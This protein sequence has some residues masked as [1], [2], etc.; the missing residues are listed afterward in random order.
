MK[1]RLMGLMR[2][3]FIQFFRDKAL[4]LL[5]L[6]TFVEIAI[7]G[8]ALTLEVRNLPTAVYDGDR[9]AESQA[10]VE[11]FVQRESF[12][13]VERLEDP[14]AV[15]RLMDRGEV[16]FALIIPAG[17]SQDLRAGRSAKV[18]IVVDGSNSSIAG[19]A[20]ADA[21]DLLREYNAQVVLAQTTRG[22]PGKQQL[23]TRVKNQIQVLYMPQLK[24]VHFIML[25]ML[26]ISV[27][28]LGVLVPAAAIVREKEAGT[29]EQLMITPITG[30]ELITAKIVPM[31]LL[32]LVGLTIGV[33]MSMWIF[34]VPLRGSLLLFYAISV[35][36]FLSS[37]G[38]GVLMGTIARN[39]QQTLL[40]AF[41]ILFPLAF[42]SGTIVP[43]Q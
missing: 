36:M 38:I 6:Y 17:F 22:G 15:D 2:K 11:A 16:Q 34:G 3:E 10:L 39:M 41:F 14:A 4:V 31:V 25:T 13:L 8:W 26:A 9:S 40:L 19:Q 20:L 5:I 32:K 29:F 24:Y 37:S 1:R 18:Q 30:A 7:C 35:L 21:S 27:L 33:A 23:L 42:L 28:L 43:V 12:R